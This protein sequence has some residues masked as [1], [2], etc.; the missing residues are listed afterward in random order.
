MDNVDKSMLTRVNNFDVL[1]LSAAMM[2]VIS[3]SYHLFGIDIDPWT[4]LTGYRTLGGLGV[5]IFFIMSGFLVARS[6]ELDPS[7]V[8]FAW[9]RFLRIMPGLVVCAVFTVVLGA[10]VTDLSLNDYFSQRGVY[11]YFARMILL[12]KPPMTLPGVFES[13]PF[14][15][16]VN[17]SLWTL[18]YE[19][20]LYF[21]LVI[22]GTIGL[23][24]K[25]L[26]LYGLLGGLL[27]AHWRLSESDALLRLGD[28]FK[29]VF[30]LGFLFFSGVTL[31]ACR[32]KVFFSKV[33]LYLV[34]VLLVGAL[35]TPLFPLM[36]ML[37]LPYLII[38]SALTPIGD[39][40]KFDKF[41]DCS[42]GV[43][44]Y[45]FPIQQTVV[46]YCKPLGWSHISVTMLS[47]GLI[48]IVSM[49]SWWLIEK[50]CLGFK[51]L[52]NNRRKCST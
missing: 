44:I 32:K 52:L 6:F 16:A 48:L 29:S 21:L 9:K 47:I 43:Y 7:A 42:Y 10:F 13:N 1:R 25:K 40:A 51:R 8:R 30:Y 27:L 15:N 14:P 23:L 34:V 2:V 39:W 37:T 5:A 45:S 41:G 19:V 50:P 24:T 46:K 3:H 38:C 28:T 31:W 12:I 49:G 33:S 22:C 20:G 17:G 36:L 11:N 4:R 26:V 18:Q 35:K